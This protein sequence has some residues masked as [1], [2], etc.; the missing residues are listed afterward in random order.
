[1]ACSWAAAVQQWSASMKW[2]LVR[3]RGHRR[4]LSEKPTLTLR[5]SGQVTLFIGAPLFPC[6]ERLPTTARFPVL[7]WRASREVNRRCVESAPNRKTSCTGTDSTLPSEVDGALR[8]GH[9]GVPPSGGRQRVH[10]HAGSGRGAGWYHSHNPA[11]RDLRKGTYSG[12]F[13]LFVVEGRDDPGKLYDQEVPILLHE[14]EPRFTTG[15][16]T[17]VE[18]KYYL[19]STGRCSAPE[20]RSE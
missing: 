12:Q 19:P 18:F 1:M 16:V 7:S 14:W 10:L 8:R 20:N 6:P 5:I 13:G 15:G 9:A 11:N 17:D 3:L 2:L 4:Y